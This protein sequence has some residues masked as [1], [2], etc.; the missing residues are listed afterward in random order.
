MPTIYLI[1]Y[2]IAAFCFI[3]AAWFGW[4]A[5]SPGTAPAPRF[6]WSGIVAFGL[7]CWVLV[8]LIRQARAMS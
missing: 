7:F 6:G 8:D 2:V 3:L 1:L 5:A 4:G